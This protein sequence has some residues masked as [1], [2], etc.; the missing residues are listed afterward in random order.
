MRYRQDPC[1]EESMKETQLLFLILPALGLCAGM[2]LT[3]EL[4][5]L[6]IEEEVKGAS[7]PIVI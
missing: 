3:R 1:N 4:L 6:P 5:R 7:R 2:P